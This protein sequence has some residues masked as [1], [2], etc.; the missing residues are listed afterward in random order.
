[1]K[2]LLLILYKIAPSFLKSKILSIVI[3]NEGGQMY[4][5]TLRTIYKEKYKIDIGYGSYGGC[6]NIKNGIPPN[7]SF[8]NW[9]SI[10]QNIRVFRANHP[11]STFTTHPLLYNPIAGFV[12]E[13]SLLRPALHVGHDVWIGEWVVILPG[14]KTIGN[15][16]IIGA[17]SIVTKDV[18]AYA[19][20]AGNP[21]KQIGKRFGNETINKLESTCWWEMS[22][23][24]LIKQVD[25]LNDII[26]LQ[27]A[28][29]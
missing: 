1:M 17:G 6:F 24:E 11:R 16:A 28:S 9:C 15:G 5:A 14:V 7:V 23:D 26:K 8:G 4:S 21:A 27:H 25:K 12:S 19:I 13:D 10:A 3:K 2:R 20:V 18:E 22:M 29:S